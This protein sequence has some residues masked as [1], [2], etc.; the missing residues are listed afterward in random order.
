MT[1]IL[2]DNHRGAAD[3]EFDLATPL[4]DQIRRC[5]DA[6][7]AVPLTEKWLSLIADRPGVYGLFIDS[8]AVY[9]GKADVSVGVRLRKH[10][11]TIAGRLNINADEVHFKCV[12]LAITWDPFKPESSLMTHYATTGLGGWNSKGFGG[13]DPGRNRD[14]TNLATDHWHRRYPLN[15]DWPCLSIEQG[16]YS[17]DVLCSRVAADVPFWFRYDKSASAIKAM[18][19]TQVHVPASKM[20]AQDL[21]MLAAESLGNN[22]QATITPSHMLLYMEEHMKYPQMKVIWPLP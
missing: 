17:V 22:W 21:V 20:A 9:I 8:K 5:F 13:N 19:S 18:Q 12:Y 10:R 6:L 11:R 7:E 2:P 15:P 16:A 3:F 14:Q 4:F 1:D